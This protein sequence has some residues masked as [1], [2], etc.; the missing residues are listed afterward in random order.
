MAVDVGQGVIAGDDQ[1][2]I[3]S[4]MKCH[5]FI[6]QH[7][8]VRFTSGGSPLR[9]L[10]SLSMLLE[11]NGYNGSLSS[12]TLIFDMVDG[13]VV[14]ENKCVVD[15][16]IGTLYYTRSNGGEWTESD[17]KNMETGSYRHGK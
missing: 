10:G 1:H 16:K 9:I 14:F 2:T 3:M 6:A 12:Y 15:R 8:R 13:G 7:C 4:M 17:W 11:P 5:D